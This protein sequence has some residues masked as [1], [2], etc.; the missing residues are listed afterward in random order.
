METDLVCL[1][2]RE[3]H[4]LAQDQHNSQIEP[5]QEILHINSL[6]SKGT[7]GVSA[8]IAC[9]LSKIKGRQRFFF[10]LKRWNLP[11]CSQ[12]NLQSIETAKKKTWTTRAQLGRRQS[13]GSL[14]CLADHP[15][16]EGL[17]GALQLSQ[18]SPPSAPVAMTAAAV[19][20]VAAN[21]NTTQKEFS[22]DEIA[23]EI[24]LLD[25]E[26]FKSI[27]V[28]EFVGQQWNKPNKEVIAPNVVAWTQWF[29]KVQ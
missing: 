20:T 15:R 28:L 4:C 5:P 10:T 7:N 21:S 29:N 24:T 25:G 6:I 19:S 17:G 12:Q 13:L 18:S 1:S 11:L 2:F 9:S 22:P 23:K 3:G 26:Y 14:T 27:S 8:W 16:F